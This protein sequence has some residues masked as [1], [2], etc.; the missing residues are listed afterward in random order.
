MVRIALINLDQDVDRLDWMTAQLERLSL[1]FERFPALRGDALPASLDR[2][3]R[4]VP[5]DVHPLSVGE[6]GC[7]ASHLAIMEQI[8]E[9]GTPVTLVLEDDLVLHADLLKVL[10]AINHLP[11]DWDMLRLAGLGSGGRVR[12][13]SLGPDLEL[14]KYA[15]VPMGTGAYLISRKGA[16]RYVAWARSRRLIDRSTTTSIGSGTAG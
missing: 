14:V 8:V 9:T 1:T 4:S 12:I 2:Y 10:D 3:F 13:T 15:R 6:V 16:A 11:A 7:Y 5:G